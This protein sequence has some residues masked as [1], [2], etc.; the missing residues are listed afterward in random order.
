MNHTTEVY[1]VV[2]NNIMFRGEKVTQQVKQTNDRTTRTNRTECF[3]TGELEIWFVV[4]FLPF[5]Y[6][7]IR[8]PCKKEEITLE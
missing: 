2:S 8:T 3:L 6:Q 7:R 5:H 4:H 1:P